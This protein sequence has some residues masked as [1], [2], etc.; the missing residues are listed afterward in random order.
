M[1]RIY[2]NPKLK[3]R[4]QELRK[5]STKA[6]RLL[7][8]HLKGKR[9]LGYGFHRQKPIGEYIV[10]FYCPKLGLVIEVDGESHHAKVEADRERQDQLESLGLKLLRFWD[11]D[12]KRDICAVVRTIEAWITGHAHP[13][14]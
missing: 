3:G 4:A 12:V 10:D 1:V 11:E 14:L 2:Y 13:L 7:W 5:N 9:M 6:E 8:A